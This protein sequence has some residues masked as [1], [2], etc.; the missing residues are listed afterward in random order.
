LGHAPCAPG[1]LQTRREPQAILARHSGVRSSCRQFCR[2]TPNE[3]LELAGRGRALVCIFSR[4]ECAVCSVEFY[5]MRTHAPWSIDLERTSIPTLQKGR[6]VTS[7]PNPAEP[8][9]RQIK[10][11]GKDLDHPNGLSTSI[12]SSRH[13][14]NS[15]VWLRS[16]PSTKRTDSSANRAGIITRESLPSARS[17]I[18]PTTDIAAKRGAPRFPSLT[19]VTIATTATRIRHRRAKAL[20]FIR[21][22]GPIA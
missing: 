4:M 1:A 11:L 13:S 8:Q 16:V 20:N 6:P 3:F 19:A 15:V 12:Q 7:G 10:P 9:L 18:R 14:G 2:L 21:D 22:I 17:Y 5:R